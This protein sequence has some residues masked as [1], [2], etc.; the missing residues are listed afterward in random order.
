MR[1]YVTERH[2]TTHLENGGLHTVVYV[3]FECRL[4]G[5]CNESPIL[6]EITLSMDVTS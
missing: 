6:V 4:V 1:R 5:L 3:D 2:Q